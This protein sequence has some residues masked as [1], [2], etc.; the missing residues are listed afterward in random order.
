MTTS[1][2]PPIVRRGLE[3]L[4]AYRDVG[5]EAAID[6]SDNTCRFGVPPAAENVLRAFTT[7]RFAPYPSA[8]NDALRTALGSVLGLDPEGIVT[9]CGS[10]DVLDAALR[11]FGEPGQRIAFP[12]P[13]FVMLGH[14]ATANGLVPVPV[15][16]RA[17]GAIDLDALLATGADHVYLC[18]PNNPTGET[19]PA[20]ALERVLEATTGLVILDEAYIEFAGGSEVARAATHGRLLVARTL[21][22]AH[23][24]AGLRVGYG[25][26]TP[27]MVNAIERARGP[28]RV[29][30]L[31]E[32]IAI[33]VVTRDAEWVRE[34]VAQANAMRDRFTSALRSLGFAPRSS[35]AN[36]VLLP[37]RDA[38]A[39]ERALREDGIAVR[40]FRE[41]PG[42]GD[43]LRITVA[44]WDVLAR[45]L[46]VLERTVRRERRP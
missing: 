44:P 7:G 38:L 3:A 16:P 10:D 25:I 45:V 33:A 17:D 19:L 32:A 4:R 37:T 39:L 28:Y 29:S 9:G 6:L 34:H 22:K 12:A 13:T 46:A 26:A 43:A 14:F 41:L 20:G 42:V 24:L 1:V 36:F 8:A 11:A 23:A 5:H 2:R 31:S 15:P 21:S 35:A 18:S 40:V 30:A 27:T